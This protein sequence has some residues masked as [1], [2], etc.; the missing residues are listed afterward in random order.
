M[1]MEY[2]ISQMNSRNSHRMMRTER[3]F[4]NSALLYFLLKIFWIFFEHFGVVSNKE[5]VHN[6]STQIENDYSP[7]DLALQMNIEYGIMQI[8]SRNSHRMMKT[9]EV[10]IT[11][12]YY[13]CLFF[14][15]WIFF[16]HFGVVSNME[17]VHNTSTKIE[18]NRSL[19]DLALM[20]K[21]RFDL[22]PGIFGSGVR[23]SGCE[24]TLHVTQRRVDEICMS[25]EED[26]G[27]ATSYG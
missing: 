5:A 8:N 21:G 14:F 1:N 2:K 23:L 26:D 24:A 4:D 16:E 18:S 22:L 19:A 13:I 7:A 25:G 11:V 20:G 15:F 3:G 17:A 12:H 9:D 10:S 6:I 27:I